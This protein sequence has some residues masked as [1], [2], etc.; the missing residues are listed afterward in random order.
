M[1]DE[2]NYRIVLCGSNAYDKKYYFNPKF[3]KLPENVQEELR[4]ISVLFTEEVGG[5][6]TIGFTPTGEAVMDTQA[7]EGDLLYDEIG[8]ALLIKKIRSTKQ[9]LFESLEIYYKVTFLHENPADLLE[10]YEDTAE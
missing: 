6:F 7:D 2:R 1:E 9:D 4:I 5:I 3:E 10:D 8:S